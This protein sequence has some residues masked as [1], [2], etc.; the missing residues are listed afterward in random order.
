MYVCQKEKERNEIMSKRTQP[1]Q[2]EHGQKTYEG[3]HLGL[4]SAGLSI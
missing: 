2:P 1:E 4:G 3:H